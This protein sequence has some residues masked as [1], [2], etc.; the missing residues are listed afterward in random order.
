MSMSKSSKPTGSMGKVK[1]PGCSGVV[2]ANIEDTE[3]VLSKRCPDC[4]LLF[5]GT[6]KPC[7]AKIESWSREMGWGSGFEG[8]GGDK[9]SKC[10]KEFHR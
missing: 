1:C 6:H 4:S 8:Q 2:E 3:D 5:E 10:G 7:K 9:C